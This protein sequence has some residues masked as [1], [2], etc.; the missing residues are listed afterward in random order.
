MDRHINS[1]GIL[2]TPCIAIFKARNSKA[3]S[4]VNNVQAHKELIFDDSLMPK[5]SN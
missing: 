5:S 4:V 3:I 2:N 1:Y